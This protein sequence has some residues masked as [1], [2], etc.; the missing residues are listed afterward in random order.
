MACEYSYWSSSQL[1]TINFVSII[2]QFIGFCILARD[3]WPL[4]VKE[5]GVM[6]A[7]WIYWFALKARKSLEEEDD[8]TVGMMSSVRRAEIM[9]SL[10]YLQKRYKDLPIK[11]N[12]EFRDIQ[13][14]EEFCAYF[15]GA[16]R[17]IVEDLEVEPSRR[18]F[19]VGKAIIII[20]FGYAMQIL[21]SIPC[22]TA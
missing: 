4:Y 12:S 6:Y 13:K 19:H 16:Q 9:T 20:F 11:T 5:R 17:D 8:F 21:A 7:R 14:V 22:G 2:L 3:M 1:E 18:F 15:A 10:E